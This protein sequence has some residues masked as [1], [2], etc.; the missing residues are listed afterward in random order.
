MKE[1]FSV[2]FNTE[3]ND[4]IYCVESPEVVRP[5]GS[6][7]YTAMRYRTTN[8]GA[9]IAYKGKYRTFVAGFPFETIIEREERDKMMSE[10]L[11]FL[12]K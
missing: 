2:K 6:G 12:I 10:V 5:A 7:A 9:A 4:K 8:Q 3:L 1:T 11:N